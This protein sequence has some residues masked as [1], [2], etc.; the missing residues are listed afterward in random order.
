M[1]QWNQKFLEFSSD[2]S[3]SL[4]FNSTSHFYLAA[5]AAE[6]K[7]IKLIEKSISIE[8]FL[9]KLRR[10]EN[11]TTLKTFSLSF[12]CLLFNFLHV[13]GKTMMRISIGHL[14]ALHSCAREMEKLK[15][16]GW[17]G[18]KMIRNDVKCC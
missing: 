12:Y 5:A 17:H 10:E 8:C 1:K 14:K 16:R 6:C 2:L 7:Y 4:I 3:H 13:R 18:K 15:E 11:R 9:M